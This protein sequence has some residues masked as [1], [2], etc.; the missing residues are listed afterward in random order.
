MNRRAG[1]AR[2]LAVSAGVAVLAAAGVLVV[3]AVFVTTAPGQVVDDVS[4]QVSVLGWWGEWPLADLVSV[5]AV[6]LALATVIAAM[7]RLVMRRRWWRALAVVVVAVGAT[8]TIQ[9]LKHALLVRPD[10]DVGPPG[11]T[12]PSGHAGAIATIA[13]VAVIASP[14]SLRAPAGALA[15]CACTLA[16]SATLLGNA[17]R[18]SDVVAAVLVVLAWAALAVP[19]ALVERGVRPGRTAATRSAARVL[20]VVAACVAV[21]AAVAGIAVAT[22]GAAAGF[23]VLGGVPVALLGGLGAIAATSAAAF[24]FLTWVVPPEA[25]LGL[26]PR[27]GPGGRRPRM[28]S[29]G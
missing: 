26:A 18:A 23:L 27:I 2:T 28:R 29:A 9:L 22:A 8:A 6:P 10:F 20:L 11:N 17:H 15:A 12:L 3:W 7:G 14:D 16:G 19:L 13:A 5:L 24:G 25:V 4:Y 21:P 1:D